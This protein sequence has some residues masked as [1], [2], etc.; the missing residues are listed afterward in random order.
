[1]EVLIKSLSVFK[2]ETHTYTET[3][4]I[5]AYPFSPNAGRIS[6]D[7]ACIISPNIETELQK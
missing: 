3:H 5:T 1:M 6:D 2:G 7:F 4:T